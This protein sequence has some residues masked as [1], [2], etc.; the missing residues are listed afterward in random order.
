ME[1]IY[2]SNAVLSA[3]SDEALYLTGTTMPVDTGP[4]AK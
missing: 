1:S 4:T 3:A 2:I